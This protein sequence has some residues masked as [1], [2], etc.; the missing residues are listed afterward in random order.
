MHRRLQMASPQD[1]VQWK[2]LQYYERFVRTN[3]PLVTKGLFCRA[4]MFLLLLAGT[5]KKQRR[6]RWAKTQWR[7]CG[8]VTCLLLRTL[9]QFLVMFLVVVHHQ[10]PCYRLIDV[11]YN[12]LFG[13]SSVPSLVTTAIYLW[14]ML[15][16]FVTYLCTINPLRAKR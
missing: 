11:I 6:C 3:K 15:P 1:F 14:Q 10:D 8:R 5:V 13:Q 2:R 16:R 7:P 12:T 9:Q 4:L